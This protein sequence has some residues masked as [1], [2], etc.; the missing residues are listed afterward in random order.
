MSERKDRKGRALLGTTLRELRRQ[1]GLSQEALGKR[2][3]LSGKFI[4][5][6]E[7]GQKSTSIDSLVRLART[8]D[9]G[10]GRVNFGVVTVR[11][12]TVSPHRGS[13]R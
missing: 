6:V 9:R 12:A 11:V 4:G 5:E 10:T 2:S 1:A 8:L 3:K 13:S 7:R